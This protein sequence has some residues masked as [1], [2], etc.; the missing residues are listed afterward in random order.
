MAT[1]T[2]INR[3]VN[4]PRAS[5]YRALLDVQAVVTWMV[6]NGM[7]SRV[8]AFNA[9][10]GCQFRISLTYDKPTRTGKTTTHTDTYHGR[11][12]TLVPN[13]QVVEGIAFE[14]IVYNQGEINNGVVTSTS[15]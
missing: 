12:L 13:E 14:T 9:R 11:F 3:H 2:R 4:A 1:S 5:I 7:T 6:P 8:H 10:K 15:P